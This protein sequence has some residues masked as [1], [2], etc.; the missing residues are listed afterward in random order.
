MMRS[1]LRE[2]YDEFTQVMAEKK[3]PYLVT[4]VDR[5]L[6]EQ[7]ALYAQGRMILRDV[8]RYRKAAE[9]YLLSDSENK[10]VTWTLNSKHI[11]NLEQ[12][13]VEARAFDFVI[14]KDDRPTWNLKVDVNEDDIP[15]YVQV[16]RIWESLGGRAGYTFNDFCHLEV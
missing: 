10:R 5:S 12:G 13:I 16:G 9:L 15:D 7:M 2:K 6:T 3:I 8:N 11:I 4:C 1:D 14:L